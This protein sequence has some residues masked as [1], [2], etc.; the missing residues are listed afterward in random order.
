MCLVLHRTLWVQGLGARRALLPEQHDRGGSTTVFKIA[1]SRLLLH[2]P[3]L[4]FTVA[5]GVTV[6]ALPPASIT[7]RAR[8][9]TQCTSHKNRLLTTDAGVNR[10]L[11]IDFCAS[12][13]GPRSSG[14]EI[15]MREKSLPQILNS[16]HS[17]QLREQEQCS[18][19]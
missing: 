16:D 2:F 19:P 13:P 7:R 11:L 18:A 9:H 5:Y 12:D 1:V 15:S 14:V 3:A 6:Y 10:M 4:L 8:L 17:A